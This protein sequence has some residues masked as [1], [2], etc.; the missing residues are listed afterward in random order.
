MMKHEKIKQIIFMKALEDE[1]GFISPFIYE[2]LKIFAKKSGLWKCLLSHFGTLVLNHSS[3]NTVFCLHGFVRVS[4]N[5][6]S[7]GLPV[8]NS[9]LIQAHSYIKQLFKTRYLS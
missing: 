3:S 4:K 9:R 1:N 5:S 8:L 2:S 6:V 7:G